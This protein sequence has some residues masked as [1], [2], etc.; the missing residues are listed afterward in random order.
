VEIIYHDHQ[1]EKGNGG[2]TL[3]SQVTR[4]SRLTKP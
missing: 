1:G 4:M 2:P 3:T